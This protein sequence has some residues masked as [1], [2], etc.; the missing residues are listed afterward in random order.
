[1]DHLER[2]KKNPQYVDNAY[3]FTQ[4]KKILDYDYKLGEEEKMMS[5]FSKCKHCGLKICQCI[6]YTKK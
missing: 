3:L 2:A 1:M 6:D 4:P 5:K